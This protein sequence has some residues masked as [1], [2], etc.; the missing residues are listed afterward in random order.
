MQTESPPPSTKTAADLID[1]IEIILAELQQLDGRL[2][3]LMQHRAGL[4]KLLGGGDV[5]NQRIRE[6]DR[7]IGP[8]NGR[9]QRLV[10]DFQNKISKLQTRF[11][12]EF[13]AWHKQRTEAKK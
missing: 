6:Y 2:G 1:A 10:N 7:D 9:K 13:E 12:A 4:P 5:L 3:Y 8:V 11:P